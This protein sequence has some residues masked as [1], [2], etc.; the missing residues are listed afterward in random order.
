MLSNM[1]LK[2]NL[3]VIQSWRLSQKPLALLLDYDGTLTPIAPTPS[4]AIIAEDRLE[5]LVQLTRHSNLH[6]A[7]V[8]GRSI[9]QLLPMLR[10]LLETN[11]MLCGSHGAEIYQPKTQTFLQQP[12]ASMIHPVMET[13]QARLNQVLTQEKLLDSGLL[14]E[15]KTFSVAIHVRE[16]AD[17]VTKQH[18]FKLFRAVYDSMPSLAE[19]FKLQSGKQMLEVL[20]SRANKGGGI[21]YLCDYWSRTL[22][23]GVYPVFA[24]DDLTDETGFLAVNALDGFSIRIGDPLA[25]TA[26]HCVIPTIAELYDLLALIGKN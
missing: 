24:G 4:E 12:D 3:D 18:I 20:E 16:V 5:A 8:S 11:V 13:F 2:T 6:L 25:E 9:A 17:E 23:T 10:Q 14:I 26:A 21:S 19:H 7:I 15:V 22:G 1:P